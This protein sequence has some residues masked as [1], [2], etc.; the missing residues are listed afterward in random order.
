MKMMAVFFDVV[1]LFFFIPRRYSNMKGGLMQEIDD[2]KQSF[3]IE[4]PNKVQK[5][6]KP[7]L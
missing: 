3:Q 4:W 6:A 5:N 1:K 7:W 2:I